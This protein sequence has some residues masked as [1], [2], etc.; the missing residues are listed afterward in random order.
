[1]RVL[2][3]DIDGV[4]NHAGCMPL[5]K[6][7]GFDPVCCGLV[8]MI[9]DA[10]DCRIVISSTWRIGETL[11]SLVPKLKNLGLACTARVIGMTPNLRHAQ[12]R[13]EEGVLRERERVDEISAW[14]AEHPEVERFAILDDDNDMRGVRHRLVL[15][16]WARGLER[17]QA[18]RVIQLLQEAA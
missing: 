18:R 6:E 15:T 8:E 13:D 2:F 16:S 5:R 1:M 9:C 17:A 14:L 10:T 7:R 3:L 4:L 12:F 11:E